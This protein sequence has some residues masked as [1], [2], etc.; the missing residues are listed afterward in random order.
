MSIGLL[1]PAALTALAAL[2]LPLLIH[3]TRRSDRQLMTFAALRWLRAKERARRRLRIDEWVLLALRLLLLAAVVVLLAQPVWF[4]AGNA[5]PW[6]V[7]VPG[8]DPD[9]LADDPALRAAD[10]HWL[11]P[12]FPAF[13]GAAP[14]PSREAASLLRELDATLAPTQPLTVIVPERLSGLDGERIVLGRAVD[15]HVVAALAL[16]AATAPAAMTPTVAIRHDAAHAAI[17]RYFAAAVN[18]WTAGDDDRGAEPSPP[19][20]AIA[21]AAL[22]VALPAGTDWLLWLSDEAPPAAIASWLADGGSVLRVARTATA[23]ADEDAAVEIWRSQQTTTWLSAQRRG[24]GRM[25]IVHGAPDV[26]QLP[27]VLH[28]EFALLLRSWLVP[29]ARAPA[30]AMARDVAP[31]H[32]LAAWPAHGK[33]LHDAMLWLIIALWLVERILASARRKAARA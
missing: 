10:W 6:V 5:Q 33:P 8:A 18:A 24:R 13:G 9:A 19:S 14:Q 29:P 4:A 22:D 17:S 23:D 15:W 2:A 25:L 16:P 30:Q 31:T 11:A 32:G 7:V 21:P 20:L 3:L 27:E 12:G 28:P 26:A 1:F